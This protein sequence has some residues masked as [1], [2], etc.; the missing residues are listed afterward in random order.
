MQSYRTRARRAA[1]LLTASLG[2]AAPA[3]RRAVAAGS[4]ADEVNA[5]NNPLTP[6]V[7]LNLQDYLAPELN[8]EPGRRSNQFLLRG[9]APVDTFGLPQ[10]IRVTLPVQTDPTFPYGS[11]TGLGDTSLYDL[12]VFPVHGMTVSAGPVLVA[13]TAT[14]TSTGAGKWQ[15]GGAVFVVAEHSWGLTAGLLTYQHSFAGAADRPTAQSLTAQP[16]LTYNLPGA[17]YLRS[18]GIW[19]FN[20][21]DDPGG[22]TTVIPIGFGIGKVWTLGRTTLNLFL[23]PQ[24]SVIRSGVG[25]PV[26]QVFGGFNLQ[27]ALG[28]P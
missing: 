20:L 24:Y 18:T 19:S 23:E 25:V 10:L 13:P 5:A 26:W 11:A 16:I 2:A 14:S 12:F 27:V 22:H 17:F 21:G 3:A 6:K 9:L 4:G 7:T 1:L 8:R 15:A 28:G